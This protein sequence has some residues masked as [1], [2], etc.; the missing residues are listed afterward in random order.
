MHYRLSD[1]VASEILNGEVVALDQRE[2][3]YYSV[4]GS[5]AAMWEGLMRGTTVDGLVA[6]LEAR[7][8][9]PRDVVAA[10]VAEM[11]ATLVK[12]GLLAEV[13][14]D[15]PPAEPYDGAKAAWSEAKIERFNDLQSL[16]LLD[17]I[18]DVDTAG[19][20]HQQAPKP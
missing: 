20:P 1:R 17:P 4:T 5:G 2:L 9:A 10:A 13:P 15:P 14:G 19:W 7:Y 6:A 11:V 12:D 3:S 16:L 8:D 18:H